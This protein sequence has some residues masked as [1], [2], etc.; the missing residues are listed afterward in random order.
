[1][2]LVKT[3]SVGHIATACDWLWENLQFLRMRLQ[4]L[5]GRGDDMAELM[6]ELDGYRAA[7]ESLSGWLFRDA[8]IFEVGY[9]ARPLR[10]LALTSLGL[11]ARGIDLDAPLLSGSIPELLRVLR[12]NG[13]QR[14]LKSTVRAKV[15]DAHE[16]RA[17]DRALAQRG[18]RLRIQP[19][20][21]LVG[22]IATASLAP[23][24]VDFFCSE[25]VFE[26][27]PRDAL[28]AVCASMARALTPDGVALIAP[29]VFTGIGGGHLVEWYAHTLGSGMERR[30][31]PWEHLRQ[32]RFQA[33]CFLNEMRLADY[34]R[35]FERHFRVEAVHN[36]QAGHG[37]AFLTED[38]I[39]ELDDYSEEELLGDKWRFV[40]RKKPESG[41]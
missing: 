20:R 16:R 33:D 12:T 36:L 29:A 3:N 26:H 28:D 22:D 2:S 11:N 40:L 35:L 10:L 31:E 32:R 23:S 6:A 14:F 27:I 39:E 37:A 41:P 21:F 8:A 24:S 5:Q 19:E 38:V 1:M 34:R 18:A 13:W 17:L 30:S 9:G 25:D 4:G 7:Y 15:F